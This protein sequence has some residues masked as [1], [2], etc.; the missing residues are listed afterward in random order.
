MIYRLSPFELKCQHSIRQAR[1]RDG[2][3]AVDGFLPPLTSTDTQRGS[4]DGY[5]Y[6]AP[7]RPRTEPY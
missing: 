1:G 4:V 2:P 6:A 3:I 7:R 5:T